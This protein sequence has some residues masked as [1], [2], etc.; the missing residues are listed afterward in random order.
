MNKNIK[1]IVLS[2]ILPDFFIRTVLFFVLICLLTVLSVTN[3]YVF[4]GEYKLYIIAKELLF[5]AV[6]SSSVGIGGYYCLCSQRQIM[7]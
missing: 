7:V 3:A 6:G 1:N 4:S 5:S 2:P